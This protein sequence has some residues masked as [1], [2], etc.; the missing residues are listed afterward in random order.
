MAKIKLPLG[1]TISRSSN[2]NN[3]IQKSYNF[4]FRES[5]YVYFIV[6]RNSMIHGQESWHGK[7]Y[8]TSI[9]KGTHIVAGS[10]AT[11]RKT[12]Y[13]KLRMKLLEY[14]DPEGREVVRKLH[15]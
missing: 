5:N 11:G 8:E 1:M 7:I 15:G 10:M 12:M 2:K 13:N 6:K 9:E 3:T 4:R 14:K